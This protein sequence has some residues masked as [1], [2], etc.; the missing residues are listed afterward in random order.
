MWSDALK[1]EFQ[2]EGQTVIP[3]P[4]CSPLKINLGTDRKTEVMMM[5]MFYKNNLLN[6]FLNRLNLP[7]VSSALCH[8]G[9]EDQTPYHILLR[10]QIVNEDLRSDAMNCVQAAAEGEESTVLL[11]LS[12]DHNF[13]NILYEI[14]HTQKHLLR[15]SIEL[16]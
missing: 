2:N 3:Q 12:R 8:C 15:S 9:V 7:E 1:N 4:S 16:N 6:S 11:N 13:M 5:S 10:C 14:M